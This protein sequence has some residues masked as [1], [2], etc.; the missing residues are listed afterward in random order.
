MK[1]SIQH[2][3]QRREHL[4]RLAAYQRDE[5]IDAATPWSRAARKIDSGIATL[6]TSPYPLSA[7]LAVA[8]ALT[9]AKP[10]LVSRWTKR[11]WLGFKMVQSVRAQR[12]SS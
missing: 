9:L 8:V 11:V 3:T 6:R 4:V 1:R 2:Y 7:I 10:K 5:M 12:R